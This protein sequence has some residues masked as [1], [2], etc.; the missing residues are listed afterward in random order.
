VYIATRGGFSAVP[1]PEVLS[2][3]T[4]IEPEKMS[5]SAS[6]GMASGCSVQCVRS[7]LV[8]WPQLMLP[9]RVPCGLYW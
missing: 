7:V 4:T 2:L 9:Q 1:N 6:P 5:D 8:A 3:S